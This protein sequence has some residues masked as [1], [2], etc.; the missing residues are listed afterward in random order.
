MRLHFILPPR[1]YSYMEDHHQL[2]MQ[3][4]QSELWL[5][6]MSPWY[7]AGWPIGAY[8]F[9]LQ[10]AVS[11]NAV[12]ID[13]DQL[14]RGQISC[15]SVPVLSQ[16]FISVFMSIRFLTP[17]SFLY[18]ARNGWLM[19]VYCPI[20]PIKTRP[21]PSAETRGWR[22][23]YSINESLV[24]LV[25]WKARPRRMTAGCRNTTIHEQILLKTIYG[26]TMISWGGQPHSTENNI[27]ER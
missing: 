2:Y 15:T 24:A 10:P 26:G 19:H 4:G 5:F 12:F 14:L 23:K 27:Q 21:S 17:P 9:I 11:L 6:L 3:E 25:S 1:G 18:L 7:R 16:F 8:A 20:P 22:S 13:E